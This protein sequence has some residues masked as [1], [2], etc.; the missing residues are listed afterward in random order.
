MKL[1]ILSD[2][3][4]EFAGFTPPEIDADVVVLAGDIGVGRRENLGAGPNQAIVSP[5]NRAKI[6]PIAGPNVPFSV[7][8][9]R[10]KAFHHSDVIA[11]TNQ[12]ILGPK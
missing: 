8:K 4:S 11:V 5:K 7:S 12:L 3:H 6:L 2:L 9:S 10:L 1:H